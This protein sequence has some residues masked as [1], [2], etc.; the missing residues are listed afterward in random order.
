MAL[1]SIIIL[2]FVIRCKYL[3]FLNGSLISVFKKISKIGEGGARF[4]LATRNFCWLPTFFKFLEPWTILRDES[5]TVGN[6]PLCCSNPTLPT[7]LPKGGEKLG[8]S[9]VVSNLSLIT[10]KNFR[11]SATVVCVVEV[12]QY[13]LHTSPQILKLKLE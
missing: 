11:P 9:S 8:N 13:T 1:W 7:Y 12:R 2:H 6:R 3:I 5:Q 10:Y 4:L